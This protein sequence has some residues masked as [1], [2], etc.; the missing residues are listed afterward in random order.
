[1]VD[2]NYWIVF[3]LEL[4]NTTDLEWYEETRSQRATYFVEKCWFGMPTVPSPLQSIDFN[5]GTA[6]HSIQFSAGGSLDLLLLMTADT[7]TVAVSTLLFMAKELIEERTAS[8]P[9]DFIRINHIRD[10]DKSTADK[11]VKIRGISLKHE[12]DRGI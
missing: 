11:A 1:M 5:P 9:L 7:H 12:R 8:S 3:P 10:R 6:G 4:E 2:S